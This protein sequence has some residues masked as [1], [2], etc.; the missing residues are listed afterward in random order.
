MRSLGA[1]WCVSVTLLSL[2][3]YATLYSQAF[4]VAMQMHFQRLAGSFGSG[5]KHCTRS[6]LV[7]RFLPDLCVWYVFSSSFSIFFL[8]FLPQPPPLP[9]A[10][11]YFSHLIRCIQL[12]FFARD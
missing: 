6:G 9:P 11:S 10:A 8:L 7:S 1:S 2:S 5:V 4:S 12:L 3:N